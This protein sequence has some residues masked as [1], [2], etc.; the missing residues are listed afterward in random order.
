M[1]AGDFNKLFQNCMPLFIALG[2]QVRLTIIQALAGAGLYDGGGNDVS[3]ALSGYTGS[4]SR[5][6]NVKEITDQLIP[7][8][9]FPSFKNSKGS[10]TY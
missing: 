6:M 5:G 1:E 4:R 10:R 3:V 7:P 8:R 2:D 9:H